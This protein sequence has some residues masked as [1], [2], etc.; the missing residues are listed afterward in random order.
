MYLTNCEQIENNYNKLQ[1]KK[2]TTWCWT[3]KNTSHDIESN[4]GMQQ[5][6]PTIRQKACDGWN[7]YL[8]ISA[9]VIV[10]FKKEHKTSV[11]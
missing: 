8:T 3:R 10:M 11:D 7:G 1:Y 6:Q 5:L 2:P 9:I 4:E